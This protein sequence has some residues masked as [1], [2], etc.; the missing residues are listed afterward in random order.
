[1]IKSEPETDLQSSETVTSSSSS[2]TNESV[3]SVPQLTADSVPPLVTENAPPLVTENAPPL[4]IE[5]APPLVTENAPP[6]VIENAPQLTTESVPP[7]TTD[8]APLPATENA[9]LPTTE[10]APP[11]TTE[12]LVKVEPSILEPPE[13]ALVEKKNEEDDD[14]EIDL[15]SMKP[16]DKE[17][18]SLPSKSVILDAMRETMRQTDPVI[19]NQK[20]NRRKRKREAA[21]VR[22]NQTKAA[23]EDDTGVEPPE[24]KPLVNFSNFSCKGCNSTTV[25]ASKGD[26]LCDKCSVKK[27]KNTRKR[28][29][30]DVQTKTCVECRTSTVDGKSDICDKC[31]LARKTASEGRKRDS[32]K[33]DDTPARSKQPTSTC[34]IEATINAVVGSF[35]TVTLDSDTSSQA[36]ETSPLCNKCGKACPKAASLCEGCSILDSAQVGSRSSQLENVPQS[37]PVPETVVK[38]SPTKPEKFGAPLCVTCKQESCEGCD[39]HC[40]R[41]NG[42]SEPGKT[43]C[44]KCH[45]QWGELDNKSTAVN[46]VE[47]KCADC[48]VV[49][50]GEVT[51]RKLCERC[52][53]EKKEALVK[54]ID[55]RRCSNEASVQV[56]DSKTKEILAKC[57]KLPADPATTPTK[58]SNVLL[59][60]KGKI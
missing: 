59:I 40:F 26:E 12:S 57:S 42:V 21:R 13:P 41:C 7:P 17:T 5:N 31:T 25:G 11:P 16:S 44:R 51:L 56:G 24:K 1:M 50:S 23:A 53:A 55:E 20:F 4:V 37:I 33:K 46:G 52:N 45:D 9:P 15:E 30:T 3:E 34:S 49:K 18:P 36:L 54:E 60:C 48:S 39:E 2:D 8:D 29:P 22:R 43:F 28:T 6:L 38:P 14:R 47:S 32:S 58:S 35:A 27:E 10:N 19:Q